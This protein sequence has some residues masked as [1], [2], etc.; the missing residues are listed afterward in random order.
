MVEKNYATL[1]ERSPIFKQFRTSIRH[2]EEDVGRPNVLL[3]R[4]PKEL[5]F[6]ALEVLLEFLGNVTQLNTQE[7]RSSKSGT[8][9]AAA[10]SLAPNSSCFE[11]LA[12][13]KSRV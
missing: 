1:A 9:P 11:R 6:S 12:Q 4:T 5:L 2:R 7:V 10:P 8:I 3:K 13:K